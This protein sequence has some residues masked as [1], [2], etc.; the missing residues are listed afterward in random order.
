MENQYYALALHFYNLGLNVTCLTGEGDTFY[1]PMSVS[2][3]SYDHVQDIQR[4]IRFKNPSHKYYHLTT[5]RQ[6][7]DELKSYDWEN[8]HGLGVIL[9]FANVGVI[10]ID[11][12][13]SDELI[14]HLL[15]KLNLPSNYEWVVRTGNGYHIYFLM[16]DY[17]PGWDKVPNAYLPNDLNEG[18][19]GRI[20]LRLTKSHSILPNSKHI[21]GKN[22][23][24]L[25]KI[26]PKKIPNKLNIE[27]IIKVIGEH[28]D[29]SKA[30]L[31]DD[32]SHYYFSRKSPYEPFA[33]MAPYYIIIDTETN[34]L[35]ANY[36]FD[37]DNL[38]NWPNILQIAWQIYDLDFNLVKE[39]SILIKPKGIVLDFEAMHI[40]HLTEQQ[41]IN[42]GIDIKVVIFEF[43][44]DLSAASIVVGHNIEFD[45]NIIKAE[46]LR[47]NMEFKAWIYEHNTNYID[48]DQL[49]TFCTMNQTAQFVG[50]PRG[51]G[52]KYPTL[53]ELYQKLFV[54]KFDN[55]HD[56]LEDVKATASCFKELIQAHNFSLIERNIYGSH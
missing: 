23:H 2:I 50:I 5:K 28:C 1:N 37:S 36:T 11:F 41:L 26:L 25:L 29:L 43:L 4:E 32:H 22:Y 13:N 49:N 9:G 12:C 3:G 39:K 33:Y 40:N 24:F 35:P 42:D 38:E 7:I 20:E 56:A 27:S 21:N 34:G 55:A 16:E 30:P 10:D 47:N 48:F 14:L 15:K 6:E 17:T 45:L 44:S 51:D 31:W 18:L 53:M 19:F 8:A 54:C 46:I 52:Y